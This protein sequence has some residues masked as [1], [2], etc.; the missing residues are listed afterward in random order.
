MTLLLGYIKP[1]P[2][3]TF[4]KKLAPI[5]SIKTPRKSTFYYFTLLAIVSV[6]PFSSTPDFFS[7]LKTSGI[8][9]IDFRYI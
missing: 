4:S 8:L 5:I 2:A 3:N 1:L 6:V 9:E 7:S